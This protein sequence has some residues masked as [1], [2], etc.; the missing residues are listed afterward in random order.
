MRPT[1]YPQEGDCYDL[2]ALRQLESMAGCD[3]SM[4]NHGYS[5]FVHHLLGIVRFAPD[6]DLI[7]A[8]KSESIELSLTADS[9]Y[10]YL[11]FRIGEGEWQAPTNPYSWYMQ[12]ALMWFPYDEEPA[13]PPEQSN[14]YAPMDI[15]LMDSDAGVCRASRS[16]LLSPEFTAPL[17]QAI[18]HQAMM[19]FE[20]WQQASA[21]AVTYWTVQA[22]LEDSI[23]T[24]TIPALEEPDF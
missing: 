13:P 11:C 23:A 16:A 14:I 3:P 19:T 10:I 1:F 21:E 8:V 24:M 22:I 2:A 20:G 15:V 4:N 18:R 12:T 6:R 17:H 9:A 7:E 5:F